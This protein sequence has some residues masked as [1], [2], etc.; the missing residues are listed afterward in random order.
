MTGNGAQGETRKQIER[1]LGLTTSELNQFAGELETDSNRA[2]Y[3]DLGL[4]AYKEPASRFINTYFFDKSADK[5]AYKEN[6]SRVQKYD[7]IKFLRTLTSAADKKPKL[8]G[9]K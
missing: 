3:K 7:R 6:E 5:K 9:K 4:S 8:F 2:E 1:V